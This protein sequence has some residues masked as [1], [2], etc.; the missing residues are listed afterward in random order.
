MR[1]RFSAT[2]VFVAGAYLLLPELLL[3]Q[4]SFIPGPERGVSRGPAFVTIGDMDN[5]GINDVVV[6]TRTDDQVVVL[7]SACFSLSMA[8]ATSRSA[9]RHPSPI[10]TV[11]ST[12]PLATSTAEMAL[13]SLS[14]TV[15][16]VPS[17]RT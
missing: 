11:H 14:R 9:T 1:R 15:S 12:L 13:I 4:I 5:D 10:R 8:A 16:G 6:S 17:R 3:A 2:L 7:V